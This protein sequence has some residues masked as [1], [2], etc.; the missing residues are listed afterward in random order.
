MRDE[1]AR[2]RGAGRCGRRRGR[3]FAA[4]TAVVEASGHGWRRAGMWR[5]LPVAIS[6]S[7]LVCAATSHL[8]LVVN[9]SVGLLSA[10]F[11]FFFL[12]TVWLAGWLLF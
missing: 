9:W 1:S 7:D 11:R 4:K 2:G 3:D 8:C 10:S 12:E 5:F 6:R